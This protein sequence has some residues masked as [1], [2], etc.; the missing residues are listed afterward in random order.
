[1]RDETLYLHVGHHGVCAPFA[2][3]RMR[4]DPDITQ[5]PRRGAEN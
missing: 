1:M 2:A 4:V 5:G 3:E